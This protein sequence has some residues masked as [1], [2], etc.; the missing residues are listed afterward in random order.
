MTSHDTLV[1][2][3]TVVG[4]QW[5]KTTKACHWHFI[6]TLRNHNYFNKSS[7]ICT[8]KSL[9]LKDVRWYGLESLH[10]FEIRRVLSFRY[11]EGPNHIHVCCGLRVASCGNSTSS[12]SIIA[13]GMKCFLNTKDDWR[14]SSGP[15]ELRRQ[16]FSSF[17][18]RA[19][20]FHLSKI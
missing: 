14:G 5:F 11:D 9:R 7:M 10:S 16:R 2:H 15:Q 17:L 3:S 19:W 20:V 8:F 18:S 12:I 4:N 1:C 13:I 6:Y